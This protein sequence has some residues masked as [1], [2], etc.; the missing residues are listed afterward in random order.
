MAIED[1]IIDEIK[2]MDEV[3]L[4]GDPAFN[5]SEAQASRGLTPETKKAFEFM[6]QLMD[7]DITD[8]I[9][10]LKAVEKLKMDPM[11]EYL[12]RMKGKGQR[13]DLIAQSALEQDV[14]KEGSGGFMVGFGDMLQET[15]GSDFDLMVKAAE[16]YNEAF[17]RDSQGFGGGEQPENLNMGEGMGDMG[18]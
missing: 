9:Y 11:T 3:T 1:K 12:Y 17:G 13:V 15:F 4:F 16:L 5:L 7:K 14:A 8:G 2:N 6:S 10:D 18:Y